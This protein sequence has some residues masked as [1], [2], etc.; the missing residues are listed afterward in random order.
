[1]RVCDRSW[2]SQTILMFLANAS[3]QSADICQRWPDRRRRRRR[4]Q[5]ATEVFHRADQPDLG[6]AAAWRWLSAG[7]RSA[8]QGRAGADVRQ[9]RMAGTRAREEILRMEP[10]DPDGRL[11]RAQRTGRVALEPLKLAGKPVGKG[12]R[13]SGWRPPSRPGCWPSGCPASPAMGQYSGATPRSSAARCGCPSPPA[14]LRPGRPRRPH[15]ASPALRRS[16]ES[17]AVS[18]RQIRVARESGIPRRACA[19]HIRRTATCL[20][21]LRVP[22]CPA[23]SRLGP[24]LAPG[25]VGWPG[26]ARRRSGPNAPVQGLPPIRLISRSRVTPY[27]ARMPPSCSRLTGSPTSRP[28]A[29]ISADGIPALRKI[30]STSRFGSSFSPECGIG[31]PFRWRAGPTLRMPAMRVSRRGITRTRVKAI[32]AF[33]RHRRQLSRAGWVA[34]GVSWALRGSAQV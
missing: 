17:C 11:R 27:L 24:E 2:F 13:W 10:G 5:S 21:E 8:G 18:D 1:M 14:R 32:R 15:R 6:A 16:L 23:E 12:S 25:R 7:T 20:V 3:M 31:I 19:A 4:G 28:I 34:A 30:S 22:A 26:L 33:L 9:H 29:S